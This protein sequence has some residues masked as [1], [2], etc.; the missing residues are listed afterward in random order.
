MENKQLESY[1]IEHSKIPLQIHIYTEKGKP[2]PQYYLSL[3]NITNETKRI[4]ERI[5]EDIIT[6]LSFD[7]SKK[8]G[9]QGQKEIKEQ[10]QT[11]LLEIIK[12]QFS[13]VDDKTI[14][15]ISNYVIVTSLGLAELDFLLQDPGLEEV[16]VNSAKDPVWCTTKNTDG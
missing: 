16:V 2:V 12:T 4:I 10:F 15:M 5:R 3:L 1:T 14:E 11:K 8:K 7:L 9:E 6:K 13:G